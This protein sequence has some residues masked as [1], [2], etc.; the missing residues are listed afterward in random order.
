LRRQ[1]DVAGDTGS[2]KLIRHS[3]SARE[4][5]RRAFSEKIRA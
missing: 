5:K 1:E 4:S 2:A 3:L